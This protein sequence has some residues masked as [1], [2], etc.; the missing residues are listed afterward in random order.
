MGNTNDMQDVFAHL[1][2]SS[3]GTTAQR[4]VET[5]RQLLIEGR[6]PPGTRLSEEQFA[7]A[8][9]VSRNTLREAFRLLAHQR[10]LVHEVNRGVFVRELTRD[11]VCELYDC[12][13][14]LET[15]A[16]SESGRHLPA[17][18]A[19]LNLALAEAHI[20][21]A[22]EDARGLGTANMHFHA[23]LGG[24]AHNE[25]VNDV[26]TGLLAELRLAFHVTVDIDEFHTSFVG[27]NVRICELVQAGDTKG[28]IRVLETY[29][30]RSLAMLLDAWDHR[31][32]TK[33]PA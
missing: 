16:L 17:D 15:A 19:R 24:L 27:D 32:T 10:L 29:T 31:N 12:R 3:Q 28:A 22:A 30:D 8:L 6:I 5:L 14:L 20:A 2:P 18:F 1:Q 25:R 4:V 21:V 13:R 11:E 7:A 9:S 23:A 33:E 26:M